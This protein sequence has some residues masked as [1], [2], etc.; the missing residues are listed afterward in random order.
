MPTGYRNECAKIDTIID[1]VSSDPY[2]ITKYYLGWPYN[3]WNSFFSYQPFNEFNTIN[4]PILFVQGKYDY[5][6]PIESVVFIQ[7]NYANKQYKYMYY[8]MGHIPDND[9]GIESILNDISIWID[10]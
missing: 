8:N 10:M 9:K 1:E 2:S 7:D 4:I 3:R 6:S 5:S